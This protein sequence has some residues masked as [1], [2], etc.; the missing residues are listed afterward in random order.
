M[1]FGFPQCGRTPT[2]VDIVDWCNQY[3]SWNSTTCTFV[4][5]LRPDG[6]GLAAAQHLLRLIWLPVLLA[7]RCITHLG[8]SESGEPWLWEC[9]AGRCSQLIRAQRAAETSTRSRIRSRVRLCPPACPRLRTRRA[10]RQEPLLSPLPSCSAGDTFTVGMLQVNHTMWPAC[11]NGTAPCS[12]SAN[13]VCAI[14]MYETA[15]WSAW[16][17]SSRK[18][19]V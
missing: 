15:G 9:E 6:S 5:E 8:T 14:Q 19:G 7:C 13:L 1:Q 12:S 11:S 10:G 4:R 17:T 3:S 2:H 18:C 16:P